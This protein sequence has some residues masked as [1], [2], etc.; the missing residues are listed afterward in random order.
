MARQV[1]VVTGASRGIGR[2]IALRLA[3]DGADLCLAARSG[4]ARDVAYYS[5]AK[6]GVAGFARAVAREWG[7]RGVRVSCLAPAGSRPT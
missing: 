2:A 3:E 7:P 6:A 1:A 4:R 5:G